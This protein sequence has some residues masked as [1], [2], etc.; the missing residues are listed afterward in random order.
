MS[1]WIAFA[2]LLL[3]PFA[4]RLQTQG[5]VLGRELR[6][7]D[8]GEGIRIRFADTLRADSLQQYRFVLVFSSAN[9][10]LSA[11][12]IEQ[13]KDFVSKGGSLYIG[14]DNWPFFEESNQLT[15]A[16]FGKYCWGDQ[17]LEKAEI[18]QKA[19][20]N[21][22][23]ALRKEIPSGKTT[24]SFPM[25]YRLKVEAWSGDEPLI[26][27]GTFG[28]GKIILDG[29]YARFNTEIFQSA[30]TEE[31]FREMIGFLLKTP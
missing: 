16:F 5:L 15:F 26:L 3:C 22:V 6:L 1:H 31:I 21:E 10:R 2:L 14:A 23:F 11:A 29:G 4:G 27:S 30:E 19:C 28:Q 12:N 18:N 13:L 17:Q 9:S 20:S 8:P 25:D 7:P 24:V